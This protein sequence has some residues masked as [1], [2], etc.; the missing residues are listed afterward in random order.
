MFMCTTAKLFQMKLIRIEIIA[1]ENK[2]KLRYISLYY[3]HLS[4]WLTFTLKSSPSWQSFSGD[5]C[6][7]LCDH[8]KA[9]M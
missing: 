2:P 3:M 8:W 1:N 5:S 4:F 7:A 6:S 9:A